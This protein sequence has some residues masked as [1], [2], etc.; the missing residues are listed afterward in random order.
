MF[1]PVTERSFDR[2]ARRAN[3]F[4][5]VTNLTIHIAVITVM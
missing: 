2:S 5:Q 4:D 1:L 3:L